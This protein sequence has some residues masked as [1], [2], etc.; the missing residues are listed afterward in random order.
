VA[1]QSEINKS[2]PYAANDSVVE[3]AGT[4]YLSAEDQVDVLL[5]ESTGEETLLVLGDDYSVT[6]TGGSY[7]AESFTVT[8]VVTYS[9]GQTI[10]MIR[11]TP[12]TQPTTYANG[13]PYT[14]SINEASYDRGV[15][16]V[17]ELK[18]I[19][20]R[21]LQINASDT[22]TSVDA[23]EY[24]ATIN[25]SAA[26]A[27]TSA[28]E[29]AASA[30]ASAANAILAGS[31]A[32]A[33]SESADDASGFADAASTSADEAAASAASISDIY[34]IAATSGA[35]IQGDGAAYVEFPLGSPGE[36]LTVNGAGTDAEWIAGGG[37]VAHKATHEDGGTDEISVAGL[38]GVLA[39]AQTAAA[40]AASHQ[41]GGGDEISVLGLSGLLADAQT[42][43]AHNNTAH[44]EAYTTATAAAAL[45]TY[46]S[47]ATNGDV[48]TVAS[49]VA[50]GN[51]S[52][53]LAKLDTN[54]LVYLEDR[55]PSGTDGGASVS[56][57]WT[58][59]AFNT[60]VV[61]N[62]AGAS[63]ASSVIT[64]PAGTYWCTFDAPANGAT[65]S[66]VHQARLRQT[67]GTPATL[68]V[69][70]SEAAGGPDSENNITRT[71]GTGAFTIAAPQTF[72]LQHIVSSG[73]T[74]DGFGL[75]AGSGEHETYAR[76]AFWKVL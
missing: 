30:S 17:Q 70:S 35:L 44:S 29:S 57:V 40:H 53:F 41:D 23:T 71:M 72:E 39:D 42:P 12:F 47:L 8:T 46:E 51:D 32:A 2:G 13:G 34:P 4:F 38:S 5:A 74:G 31:H 26:A 33:A 61:N 55:R 37:L 52:R 56:A 54:S 3:F 27:A 68:V 25:A 20:D 50:A 73:R 15:E 7:P 75:A 6:P 24:L 36:I 43:L 18:E 62:V 59:R 45:V 64:L 22:T 66:T 49:T 60:E 19:T 69:G 9:T 76:I 16:Q 48:G 28:D 63:V 1:I 10:T 58:K 67:N 14:A 65:N 21:C 11:D